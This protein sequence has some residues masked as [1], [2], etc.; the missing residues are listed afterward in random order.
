MPWNIPTIA[1]EVLVV[2]YQFPGIQVFETRSVSQIL[3]TFLVSVD[4]PSFSLESPLLFSEQ[5]GRT[6]GIRDSE[7]SIS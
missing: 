5:S 1:K 2:R 3:F 4:D 6:S 7:G